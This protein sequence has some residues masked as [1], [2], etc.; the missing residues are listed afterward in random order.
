MNRFKDQPKFEIG[1]LVKIVG[2]GVEVFGEGT[3]RISRVLHRDGGGFLYALESTPDDPWHYCMIYENELASATAGKIVDG[4]FSEKSADILE[5]M[6]QQGEKAGGSGVRGYGKCAMC[7]RRFD[8]ET[9]F[10]DP[11]SRKEYRISGMCQLCQDNIFEGGPNLTM[12]YKG[13]N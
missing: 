9:E 5:I 11:L 4:T 10:K 3:A 7:P 12:G 13:E 2:K 1:D 6:R 8:P